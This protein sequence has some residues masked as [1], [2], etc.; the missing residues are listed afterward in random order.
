MFA[1]RYELVDQLGDGGMGTVWRCWDHRARVY[2]AAK[3]LRQSDASS[4]LR[5]V[6]EQ[7]YR[8]QHP[9]VVTPLGWAGEDDRVLF[10]MPIVR[11]GS[12]TTLLGDF[13]RLP[14]TW[15]AVLLDQLLDALSA[16][17]AAG[18]VH[19][20]V[21]PGNLLL[22]PTGAAPPYLRLSDFGIAAVVGGPRLT[23]T[24]AVVGTPGYFAPEHLRGAGPDPKQDLFASGVVA[25]EML[26][27]ASPLAAASALGQPGPGCPH[28]LWALVSSLAAPGPESRPES[29]SSARSLLAAT[30]LL[31]AP[32]ASDPSDDEIEV[33]DQVPALPQ[34]WDDHGPVRRLARPR[35][36]AGEASS[37]AHSPVTL[38]TR[39]T[40]Q[41]S[42]NGSRPSASWPT[43]CRRS[44]SSHRCCSSASP[45]WPQAAA[46]GPA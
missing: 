5:F 25:A 46:A 1:G 14:G 32:G 33:L 19:R 4:L 37:S 7:S 11:G 31:A 45:R 27:G 6:R 20:D 41:Q 44:T 13:G 26:T 42:C 29:A 8:V 30:G 34:G 40:P 38:L 35:G 43:R 28:D 36:R 10:T 2:V 15:V 24:S 23:S 16:V 12:V 22:E 21:K 9:H 3:V 18:L 39:S 17:H